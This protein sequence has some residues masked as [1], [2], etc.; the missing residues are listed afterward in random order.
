MPL[1]MEVPVTV[2]LDYLKT[3]LLEENT[4]TSFKHSKG[5]R[6]LYHQDR[7][8]ATIDKDRPHSTAARNSRPRRTN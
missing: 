6:L 4:G 5:T 3:T 8:L 2:I 7:E 1:L